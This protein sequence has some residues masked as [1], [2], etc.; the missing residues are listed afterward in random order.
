MRGRRAQ[1]RASEALLPAWKRALAFA[2]GKLD[3][4]EHWSA[5]VR[6]SVPSTPF[7]R[8]RIPMPKS[9]WVAHMTGRWNTMACERGRTGEPFRGS[10][11]HRLG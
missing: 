8:A 7:T 9:A 5:R 4:L 11:W 2:E 10:C 1:A 6:R 3:A